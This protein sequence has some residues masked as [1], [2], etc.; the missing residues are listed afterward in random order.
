MDKVPAQMKG[1]RSAA[2]RNGRLGAKLIAEKTG[3]LMIVRND[4][5][6]QRIMNDQEGYYLLGFRPAEQTFDRRLHHIKVQI[7]RPGLT[8][9]TREGF[10]G[11]SEEETRPPELTARDQMNRAL[12]P[13]LGKNELTVRLATFFTNDLKRGSLLNS[14]LYLDPR[15]LILADKP[16]GRHEATFELSNILFGDN[17]KVFSRLDQTAVVSLSGKNYHPS[18]PKGI[19]Y[20]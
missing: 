15:D 6:F 12:I 19:L 18:I 1:E 10:Y 8:A 13:P 16:N 14:F 4:F 2:L 3:G 20:L 9:R 11:L 7:K 5:G 17:G